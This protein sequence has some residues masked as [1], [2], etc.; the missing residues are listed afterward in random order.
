MLRSRSYRAVGADFLDSAP[1]QRTLRQTI[2]A[3]ARATFNCLTDAS[4][5]PKWLIPVTKVTWTSPEPFGVGTTRVISGPA[6]RITEEFF[7]WED[8]KRMSF[9]FTSGR[10]PLVVAFAEDYELIPTSD[11]ECELIWRYAFEGA[12]GAGVLVGVGAGLFGAAAARSI[13][14]L[15]K[16]MARH[17]SRY[18]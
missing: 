15:A 18:I 5:W 3:S 13:R 4:A 7:A 2:P 10:F 12:P 16:Y 17:R 8:G 6:G 14:N 9:R 11:T 1:V